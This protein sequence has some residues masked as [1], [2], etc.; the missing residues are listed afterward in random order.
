MGKLAAAAALLSAVVVTAAAKG[1]EEE[2]ATQQKVRK[3]NM[4]TDSRTGCSHT[5]N[6]PTFGLPVSKLRA[7]SECNNSFH[8]CRFLL[9]FPP[10]L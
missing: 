2:P 3:K 10:S 1:A 5:V 9:M 8:I 7:Q 4:V 6:I